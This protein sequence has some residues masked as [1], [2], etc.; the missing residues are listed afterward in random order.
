MY[1]L[2]V[3]I[4]H[5]TPTLDWQMASLVD[6]CYPY[7]A[8][9]YVFNFLKRLLHSKD[10]KRLSTQPST[11][12]IAALTLQPMPFQVQSLPQNVKLGIWSI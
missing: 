2:D 1:S 12:K 11:I 4:G 3:V 6:S 10:V 7:H 8:Y 5:F 9:I